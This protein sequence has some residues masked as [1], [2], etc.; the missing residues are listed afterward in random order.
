MDRLVLG[1]LFAVWTLA[2]LVAESEQDA[3][4]LTV[5]V[6]SIQPGYARS[7]SPSPHLPPHRFV[8]GVELTTA[9]NAPI[10]AFITGG[11]ARGALTEPKKDAGWATRSG[12]QM[13]SSDNRPS[14]SALLRFGSPGREFKIR[15][16]RHAIRI[17][18]VQDFD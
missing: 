17:E 2:A 18:Y 8:A 14:L 12:W 3:V 1:L 13:I 16:R 6:L 11:S 9:A 7:E 5:D 15:P 10:D 4:R